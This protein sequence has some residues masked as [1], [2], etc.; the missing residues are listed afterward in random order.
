MEIR[1][2][3]QADEGKPEAEAVVETM[4]AL[5]CRGIRTGAPTPYGC[6]ERLI[7]EADDLMDGIV[8]A[9]AIAHRLKELYGIRAFRRVGGQLISEPAL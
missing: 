2:E 8:L 1:I 4:E 7:A 9:T 5:F 6:N 3:W